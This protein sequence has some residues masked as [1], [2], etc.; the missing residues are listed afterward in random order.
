MAIIDAV[1]D[2]E[3]TPA[4]RRRWARRLE[5]MAFILTATDRA[6]PAGWATAAATALRDE[7]REIRRHPFALALARRGLD[8]AERGDAG[9]G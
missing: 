7:A 8:V 1:L 9:S 2:R 6:E 3:L 4:A 5:E